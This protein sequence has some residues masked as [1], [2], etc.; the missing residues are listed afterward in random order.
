MKYLIAVAVLLFASVPSTS[1]IPV[2]T[3]GDWEYGCLVLDVL[4]ENNPRTEVRLLQALREKKELRYW[5]NK[6]K[7][8]AGSEIAET[9]MGGANKPI[10][11]WN[12]P[13]LVDESIPIEEKH[14]CLWHE[15]AHLM[16]WR[17]E[18]VALQQPWTSTGVRLRVL[19]ELRVLCA[20]AEMARAEKIVS[21]QH[22]HELYRTKGQAAAI[23]YVAER[24]VTFDHYRE[25]P[26]VVLATAE[27]FIKN[28]RTDIPTE[29]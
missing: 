5:F 12:L 4:I 17:H 27:E 16:I 25:F 21:K 7:L 14:L 3:I 1:Q 19:N 22:F 28:P 23:R 11:E 26:K 2:M 13:Y 8:A 24:F 20:E 29:K 10:I 18:H 9:Y 15:Y 6:K